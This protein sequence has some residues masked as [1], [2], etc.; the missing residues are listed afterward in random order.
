MD[1][2]TVIGIDE[3]PFISLYTNRLQIQPADM[4]A[5][6]GAFA[7]LR[8]GAGHGSFT[9]MCIG[10][11]LN[12]DI[13]QNNV[14]QRHFRKSMEDSRCK[15]SVARGDVTEAQA[16]NSRC[17]V[18][19]GIG[20]RIQ[21]TRLT[22]RTPVIE[23]VRHE[24]GLDIFHDDIGNADIL[25]DAATAAARLETNAT[26]SASKHAVADGHIP[27]IATHIAAADHAP[28]SMHHR[29]VGDGDVF[30]GS[31]FTRA[32]AV[33]HAGFECDAVVPDVDMAVGYVDVTARVRVDPI[34]VG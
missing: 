34:R 16:F 14:S 4:S 1:F 17:A 12:V 13:M 19:D 11:H 18:V 33:I 27:Y 25:D 20:M 5:E 21:H 30:T 15:L 7:H 22:V 26:L 8:D 9:F 10:I 6:E 23:Q 3:R 2:F 31:L 28:M 24:R 32:K 29:A